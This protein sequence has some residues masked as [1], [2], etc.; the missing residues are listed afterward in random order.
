[1]KLNTGAVGTLL[2]LP[3]QTLVSGLAVSRDGAVLVTVC[4]PR[5]RLDRPLPH[6]A[7]VVRVWD[8]AGLPA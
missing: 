8:L 4:H 5:P 1:M 7:P 2:E 6:P 3:G